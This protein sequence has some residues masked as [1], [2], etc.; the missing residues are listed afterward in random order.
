MTELPLD[1][2]CFRDV[3]YPEE[4]TKCQS[5]NAAGAVIRS[6]VQTYRVGSNLLFA[7]SLVYGV[8]VFDVSTIEATMLTL[9]R[10]LSVQLVLIGFMTLKVSGQ[11]QKRTYIQLYFGTALHF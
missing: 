9:R 3:Y 10:L 8:L 6:V 7:S 5:L 1:V 4:C 2:S 11:D